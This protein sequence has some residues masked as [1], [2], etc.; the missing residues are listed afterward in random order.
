MNRL[1]L[2]MQ[3][4]LTSALRA[5]PLKYLRDKEDEISEQQRTSCSEEKW[6]HNIVLLFQIASCIWLQLDARP[7]DNVIDKS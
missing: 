7:D 5:L 3:A 2:D 6:K 4:Y 1:S